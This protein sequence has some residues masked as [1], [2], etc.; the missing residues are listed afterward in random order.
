MKLTAKFNLI[1]IVIFGLGLAETGYFARR[2]LQDRA[3]DQVLDQARLMMQT[4]TSMRTYT[5]ERIRPIFEKWQHAS[6]NFYPESVPAFSA[7]RMFAYLRTTYPDYTYREATLNP[8]N[9]DDRA[10][11]WEADVI[12]GFRNHASKKDMIGE[13]DTAT[14]RSLFFSK[15]IKVGES[16]LPCH[17][18]PEAAPAA[19]VKI[20]GRDN[21]FRWKLN[22]IV[23][24][25]I[26]SVP[27]SIPTKLADRALW[28]LMLWLG[29]VL[30]LSLIL[31]N[32]ALVATVV[33]P[34]GR[35]SAAA[36]EISR[37]NL[38]VPELPVKGRDEISVLADAFNRMHRSLSKAIKLLES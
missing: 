36:D 13:R 10:V 29:G 33:R 8:T 14:G 20:Y 32:V 35:L 4:A 6:R 1:F 16:C 25:Q 37:G 19:M 27:M 24:A 12:Q 18:T 23:A 7:N 11:D 3:R 28:Q 21:G 17:S 15:P 5:A 38:D 22:D 31:L 30:L 26:V 9:P 2:F 34:V